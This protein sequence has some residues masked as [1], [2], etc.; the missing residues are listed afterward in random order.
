MLRGAIFEVWKIM[1][2]EEISIICQVRLKGWWGLDLVSRG[3][4][5]IIKVNKCGAILALGDCL[6]LVGFSILECPRVC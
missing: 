5:N 2:P 6:C 3:K 1:T 4:H